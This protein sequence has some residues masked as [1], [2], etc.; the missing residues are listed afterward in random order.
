MPKKESLQ[1]KLERV[2]PPRVNITYDV[3]VGGAIELKELPFVVG[4]LGDFVG[5]PEE[6][7]P[8][9]KNRK[10]VEIDPDNFNQVM[11]GMKPRLTYSVDNKLQDD[12]SKMGVE[13][14]F[15]N[16]EDFEPDNIVQQ[17][18]PLRK[19]VEARQKLSDL[20]SKMDGND[21]LESML[22]DIISNSDKQKQLS[23]SL[24]LDKKEE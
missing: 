9:L 11:A 19:L 18:D 21:K 12:G 13:L 1:H 5:K 14:K 23:D 3:E 4:V 17:I 20:R 8:A 2:R 6:P 7:L 10:F 16:I 24:G 15:N 22:E